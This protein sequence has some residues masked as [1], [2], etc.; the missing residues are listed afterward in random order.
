MFRSMRQQLDA[1][2]VEALNPGLSSRELEEMTR[3][4]RDFHRQFGHQVSFPIRA[5]SSLIIEPVVSPVFL[6]FLRLSF[7]SSLLE[8]IAE[9]FTYLALGLRAGPNRH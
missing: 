7:I 1:Y 5:L 8:C 6:S 3:C 4:F 9:S 2:T